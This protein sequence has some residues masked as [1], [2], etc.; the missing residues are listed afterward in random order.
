MQITS[1]R[2][3]I[4]GVHIVDKER[5]TVKVITAVRAKTVVPTPG[6]KGALDQAEL[7]RRERTGIIHDLGDCRN[8][9][10]VAIIPENAILD[11]QCTIPA[12]IYSTATATVTGNIAAEG[13]VGYSWA[14]REIIE[15]STSILC[16]IATKNSIGYVRFAGIVIYR[17]SSELGRVS[18]EDNITKGWI[19][20][21]IPDCTAAIICG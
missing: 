9:A 16:I 1:C 17:P 10:A 11:D 18:T 7:D 15:Y 8:A 21:I 14:A 12:M 2:W 19:A 6:T 3:G 13:S 20:A 4:G 5:I